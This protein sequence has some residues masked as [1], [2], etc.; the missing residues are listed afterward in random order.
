[1]TT[2]TTSMDLRSQYYSPSRVWAGGG[3]DAQRE[4]NPLDPLLINSGVTITAEDAVIVTPQLQEHNQGAAQT[5]GTLN[6]TNCVLD[7]ANSGITIQRIDQVNANAVDVVFATSNPF[8]YTNPATNFTVPANAR[9]LDFRLGTSVSA[10]QRGFILRTGDNTNTISVSFNETTRRLRVTTTGGGIFYEGPAGETFNNRV[11]PHFANFLASYETFQGTGI[12]TNVPP[13]PN[14]TYPNT[15]IGGS[16]PLSHIW[17][18]TR[19]S[20]TGPVYSFFGN[21]AARTAGLPTYQWTDIEFEG[22][23]DAATG[24]AFISPFT[25]AINLGMSSFSNV[26]F[27]NGF[28]LASGDARGGIWQSTSG[29]IYNNTL[30]GPFGTALNSEPRQRM[31]ARFANQ[32]NTGTSGLS[33]ANHAGLATNYDMRSLGQI[34]AAQLSGVTTPGTLQWFIDIDTAANM[35][36]V[37]PLWVDLL[38]M[39]EILQVDSSSYHSLMVLMVEEKLMSLL[40]LALLLQTT[41]RL[42]PS[43]ISHSLRLQ[44]LVNVLW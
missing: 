22:D 18:N 25:G 5:A 29:A 42:M 8:G 31:I 33:L 12:V 9:Y 43:I 27:W 4:Y 39:Q 41:E 17:R 19:V 16:S 21:F 44:S 10:S 20:Y 24:E 2:F 23:V 38:Q 26:S 30:L 11:G 32:G 35:W 28:T 15:L 37:N 13:T 7:I 6:L 36:F 14:I 40:D 34:T 1:M 3:A